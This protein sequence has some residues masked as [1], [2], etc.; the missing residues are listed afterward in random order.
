MSV[1]AIIVGSGAG[2]ATAASVLTGRGLRVAVLEKGRYWTA[3]EF[4]PYD[5]LHFHTRKALIPHR[6][7]DPNIYMGGP[8]ADQPT[9]VERWWT[10]NMVGGSTMIWDANVPRYTREDFQTLDYLRDVPSDVD[11]VNWP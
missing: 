1:D 4:L 11:M 9:K 3:E 7:D 5:E 6:E 10:A 2:G 8:D